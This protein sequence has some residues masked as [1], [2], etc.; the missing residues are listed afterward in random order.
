MHLFFKIP[1]AVTVIFPFTASVNS[2]QSQNGKKLSEFV[3]CT[4]RCFWF[5]T[6]TGFMVQFCCE[7]KKKKSQWLIK[8]LKLAAV[9]TV[10]KKKKRVNHLLCWQRCFVR[11]DSVVLCGPKRLQCRRFFSRSTSHVIFAVIGHSAHSVA[12]W[13]WLCFCFHKA[14]NQPLCVQ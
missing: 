8:E 11:T 1:T 9:S 3:V 14:T 12:V 4:V 5:T 10:S 2:Q 13:I 7:K 6:R